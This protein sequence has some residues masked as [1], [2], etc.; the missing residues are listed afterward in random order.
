MSINCESSGVRWK[1]TLFT[2]RKLRFAVIA[3]AIEHNVPIIVVDPRNTSS[4]CPRCGSRL[5]YVHRLAVCRICGFKRDRD[6]V[7]AMNIWL[8]ALKAYAGEPGSSP[9]A[10]PV[11]DEARKRGRTKYEGMKQVIKSIIQTKP[12]TPNREQYAQ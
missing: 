12:S 7:G 9:S 3:K 1:L 8:R 2:Y 4:T 11:N 6:S 5:V 10:L